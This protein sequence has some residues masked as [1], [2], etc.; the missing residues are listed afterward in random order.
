MFDLIGELES[1]QGLMGTADV[2]KLLQVSRF[3]L[4]K[5]VNRREIPS[6]M[7]GGSRRF[8]PTALKNH[9]IRKCPPLRL[10]TATAISMD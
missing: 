8:D 3:T 2:C 4:A 1:H 6:F 7:V 10:R 5:M 9:F